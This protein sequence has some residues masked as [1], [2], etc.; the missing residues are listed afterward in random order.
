MVYPGNRFFT[1]VG[2]KNLPFQVDKK[3]T[4][5]VTVLCGYGG[6]DCSVGGHSGVLRM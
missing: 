5:K 3:E 6:T 4:L 2:E 1:F